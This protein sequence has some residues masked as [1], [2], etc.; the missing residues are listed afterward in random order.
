MS[1][2]YKDKFDGSK[3]VEEAGCHVR[4]GLKVLMEKIA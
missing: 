2:I 1:N 4:V 3:E